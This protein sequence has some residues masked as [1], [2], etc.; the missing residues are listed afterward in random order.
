M[1]IYEFHCHV[2]GHLYSELV[3][4]GAAADCPECGAT[5]PARRLSGFVAPRKPPVQA[6][7]ELEGGGGSPAP[8]S[9][10]GNGPI[11]I[12]CSADGG[13]VGVHI[14]PGVKLRSH[15]LRVSNAQTAIVNEGRLQDSGT[16]IK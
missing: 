4:V 11:M 8:R 10:A 1:P 3:K 13:E 2:C 6:V 9:E 5:E 16:V 7:V 12:D 15:N 14:G